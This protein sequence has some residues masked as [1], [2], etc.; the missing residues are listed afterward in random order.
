MITRVLAVGLLAGLLAGL[1]VAV[2]QAFTTTPII[3]KAEVFERGEAAPQASASPRLQPAL[4][5]STD[6]DARLILVHEGEN[7]AGETAAE[8]WSP[9]DGVERTLYTSTA[10]I[11]TAIGFALILIAGMLASGDTIEQRT[12]V[13]WA[14]AGFAATGLAPAL[15]LSPELP[16]MAASDLAGRQEWW[17]ITAAATAGALWLFLRA[18][19]LALR[20]LAVPLA[21]APHLWGAPY[22]VAEAAKSSVPPELAAQFAATSLAVQAILWVLTGF[23]VGLLWGRI[24][25][26]RAAAPAR[27]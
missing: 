18:D 26:R 3:L 24:G 25:S 23:F 7:H 13:A 20:L 1:S 4:Y 17:L 22:H 10:T 27:G 19:R 8:A 16:G 9:G 14:A 5:R 15:G 21:L 6:M 11:A 2:L 12:A